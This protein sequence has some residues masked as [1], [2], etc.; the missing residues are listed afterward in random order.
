V[1]QQDSGV[2]R[3]FASHYLN[4]SQHPQRSLGD[5]LEIA[6]G[7]RNYVECAGHP[8]GHCGIESAAKTNRIADIL[9]ASV[10]CTLNYSGFHSTMVRACALRRT[11]CPR[12]DLNKKMNKS[13]ALAMERRGPVPKSDIPT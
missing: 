12:S 7:C 5:V 9:S 3:V 8:A 4:L 1:I 10:R 2:T 13:P 11:G 6:Y